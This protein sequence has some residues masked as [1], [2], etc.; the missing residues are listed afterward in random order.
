M[1]RNLN[2]STV[3][4]IVLG[5]AFAEAYSQATPP[6]RG[7]QLVTPA[8]S[9]SI[10]TGSYHALVIGNN[11]Y[12]NLN[13]LATAVNDA[14]AMG[15][16]LQDQYGFSIKVLLD[17]TRNDIINALVEYRRSLPPDSN[18]LIYY[19]GHGAHDRDAHEA[20]WL[21]VDAGSNNDSNWISSADITSN[22][23]AIPSR[24]VLIV[25]DSCYSGALSDARMRGVHTS[26]DPLENDRFLAKV[27]SETSRTILSSGG[28]EPVADAG[29]NGHSIF[30]Q[31]LLDGLTQMDDNRFT[32]GDLYETYVKRKVAGRSDQDPHYFPVA[33]SGDSGGDFVFFR[34]SLV[35]FRA[36]VP[37]TSVSEAMSSAAT[38]TGDRSRSR[39]AFDTAHNSYLAKNYVAAFA[40]FKSLAAS[41][42]ARA[43]YVLGEMYA[44]GKGTDKS[45]EEAVRWYRA[46]ADA[47]N[48]DAMSALGDLYL[49]GDGVT[50]DPAEAMSWYR[51]A[52]DTGS[53]TA[54]MHVGYSHLKGQGVNQ[55][56][57]QAF[58]SFHKAADA[59]NPGCYRPR[60]GP[61]WE[62]K[63]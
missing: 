50:Q 33:R 32:A 34:Q 28:D 36:G 54:L 17:A 45:H 20:Y 16:L 23:R 47:G 37:K 21:P 12:Q 27:L 8:A 19:A 44:T 31:A 62:R 38:S 56:Y 7:V 52:A 59:G 24:H 49:N 30:A 55:D 41:G 57:A 9:S 29:G 46:G 58:S 2:P 42:D 26:I 53:S 13:H 1:R 40:S 25:S 18:L 43:M 60:G 14:K 6:R 3:L 5:L 4:A 51:K 35:P 15:K 39:G 10:A 63:S 22:I 48:A 11:R 61:I